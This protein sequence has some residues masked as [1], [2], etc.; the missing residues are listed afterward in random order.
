M[1]ATR[2][3]PALARD[4]IPFV[5]IGGAALTA[6]GSTRVSLDTDIAIKA[7][8]ADRVVHLAYRAELVL[9]VG[10]DQEQHPVTAR[11]AGEALAFLGDSTQGFMKFLSREVELDGVR[12]RLAALEHLKI[13]KE[14]SI[15]TRDDEDKAE[16]DGLDLEFMERKLSEAQRGG[17]AAF[18]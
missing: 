2:I 15:R 17:G 16:T 12:V 14:L 5:L 4:G 3:F 9:V 13:M 10:V 1:L 8:D 18:R 6:Y 7:V 11:T